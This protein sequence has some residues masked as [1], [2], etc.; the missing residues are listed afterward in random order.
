M[1]PADLLVYNSI[2]KEALRVGHQPASEGAVRL[3]ELVNPRDLV[4]VGVEVAHPLTFG[5]GKLVVL[6]GGQARGLE[7]HLGKL[8]VQLA[9]PDAPR[10]EL[11]PELP[12][13]Y[14]DRV[15]VT[16]D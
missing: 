14:L 1:R 7:R 5:Q 15:R 10:V 2:E 11:G 13:G 16:H 3:D 12:V 4:A 8:A 9:V 6:G